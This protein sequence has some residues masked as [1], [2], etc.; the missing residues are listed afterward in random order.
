MNEQL[1]TQ[2]IQQFE[3]LFFALIVQLQRRT[4]YLDERGI[5]D[6]I[7]KDIFKKNFESTQRNERAFNNLVEF[8]YCIIENINDLLDDKRFGNSQEIFNIQSKYMNILR[9]IITDKVLTFLIRDIADI[10]NTNECERKKD[11]L[12]KFNFFQNISLDSENYQMKFWLIK[13]SYSLFNNSAF[14]HN[15]EFAMIK[16]S[17]ITRIFFGRYPLTFE[18][19]LYKF[20]QKQVVFLDSN[21]GEECLHITVNDGSRISILKQNYEFK[22]SYVNLSFS[23]F[24][25]DNYKLSLIFVHNELEDKKYQFNI[26]FDD[27]NELLEVSEIVKIPLF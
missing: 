1:K 14:G 6:K 8:I 18:E 26:Y 15:K 9:S 21:D 19:C 7:Y 16:E 25:F 4:E 2:T 11:I 27:Q 3:N 5:I 24:Y 10:V 17:K 20:F 12:E 22:I 13:C 23:N